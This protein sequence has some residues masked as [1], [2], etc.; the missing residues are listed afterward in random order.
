MGRAFGDLRAS[1]S[2]ERRRS[3]GVAGFGAA[4]ALVVTA[5]GPASATD[6]PWQPAWVTGLKR[7]HTSA[8]LDAYQRMRTC[9]LRID[10]HES[11]VTDAMLRFKRGKPGDLVL[12]VTF[13]A[14]KKPGNKSR[15]RDIVAQWYLPKGGQPTP[16]GEWADSIQNADQVMWLHC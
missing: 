4:I 1:Y 3:L 7:I 15:M 5:A 13:E 8:G 10:R 2:T 11:W 12:Q 9:R 14:P 16:W 6:W